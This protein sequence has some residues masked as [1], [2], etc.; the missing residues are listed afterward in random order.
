M[1]VFKYEDVFPVQRGLRDDHIVGECPCQWVSVLPSNFLASQGFL[2]RTASTGWR[3]VVWRQARNNAAGTGPLCTWDARSTKWPARPPL[4][5][6]DYSKAIN[7]SNDAECFSHHNAFPHLG[8]VSR[9][10]NVCRTLKLVHNSGKAQHWFT[11]QWTS[12]QSLALPHHHGEWV[13]PLSNDIQYNCRGAS[14]HLLFN[15]AIRK[16]YFSLRFKCS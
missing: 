2:D 10:W 9:Q 3:R 6:S 14:Q 1:Y 4:L 12:W 5:L 15:S 13:G 7:R 16:G 8:F 11:Q